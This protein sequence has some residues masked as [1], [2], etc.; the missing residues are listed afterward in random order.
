MPL[1]Y[2]A[3]VRNSDE[4]LK[5]VVR[6]LADMPQARLV[7]FAYVFLLHIWVLFILHQS[8]VQ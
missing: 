6:T 3:W 7:F 8:A 2:P 4:P 5:L 1:A